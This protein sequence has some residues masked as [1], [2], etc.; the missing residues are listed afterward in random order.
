MPLIESDDGVTPS[1]TNE[2]RHRLVPLWAVV[3][4]TSLPDTSRFR[5]YIIKRNYESWL[6]EHELLHKGP[7]YSHGPTCLSPL[8]SG[9][10]C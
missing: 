1:P 9:S 6:S 7:N 4:S 5:G 10:R 3:Y 8:A 2:M